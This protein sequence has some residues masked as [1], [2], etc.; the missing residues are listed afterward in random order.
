[1]QAISLTDSVLQVSVPILQSETLPAR[2][3]GAMLV[4]Q[5]ALI[6]AGVAIASWLTFATLFSNSSLQWR[7]SR[8]S[9]SLFR[10]TD[11]EKVPNRYA[12]LLL[13]NS[14]RPLFLHPRNAEMVG[15]PRSN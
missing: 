3:R 11:N 14:A 4:I 9:F 7:V 8:T 6:N 2:N 12:S 1:M 15:Q 13:G 5:S 10:V